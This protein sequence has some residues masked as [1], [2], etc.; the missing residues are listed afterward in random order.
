MEQSADSFRAGKGDYVVV[1][2]SRSAVLEQ[3]L[4][5]VREN[6]SAGQPIEALEWANIFS[7]EYTSRDP[8][9]YHP[10][11]VRAEINLNSGMAEQIQPACAHIDTVL[12]N[13][14]S[15]AELSE[16]IDCLV[17]R[18]PSWHDERIMERAVACMS[19]ANDETKEAL[20]STITAKLAK[21]QA[22]AA[23][24]VQGNRYIAALKRLNRLIILSDKYLRPFESDDMRKVYEDAVTARTACLTNLVDVKGQIEK[25]QKED[26]GIFVQAYAA[27]QQAGKVPPIVINNDNRVDNSVT[28]KVE[29]RDSVI[30]RSAIGAIAPAQPQG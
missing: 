18:N 4:G 8:I 19:E 22:R 5:K 24:D 1:S 9:K 3:L 25:M 20:Y 17:N 11:L 23:A 10:R 29:I 30:N 27:A 26:W 2:H 28:S 14:T 12:P 15:R 7:F 6:I 21:E 13:R 16:I